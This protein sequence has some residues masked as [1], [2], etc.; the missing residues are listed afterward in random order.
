MEHIVWAIS[1]GPVSFISA[2]GQSKLHVFNSYKSLNENPAGV[3]NE[4]MFNFANRTSTTNQSYASNKSNRSNRSKLTRSNGTSE[5]DN[6]HKRSKDRKRDSIETKVRFLRKGH[7]DKNHNI[8]PI[9]YEP[10][11]ASLNQNSLFCN[12]KTIK[13]RTQTQ[14]VI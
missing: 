14:K 4:A 9:S 3:K 10:F 13:S 6:D 5:Y 2:Y 8:W 7:F 12:S 11:Y 1:Y